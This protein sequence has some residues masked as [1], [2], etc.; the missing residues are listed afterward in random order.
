M[1]ICTG[2]IY[3]RFEKIG[4]SAV[5]WY[6]NEN[7]DENVLRLIGLKSITLLAGEDGKVPQKLAIIPFPSL[8][9]ALTGTVKFI[10]IKDPEARGG[11]R[12]STLTVLFDQIYDAVIY[13]HMMTEFFENLINEAAK[14]IINL[15]EKKEFEAEKYSKIIK[16]L[17]ETIEKSLRK[18]Q[19]IEE[20]SEFPSDEMEVTEAHEYKF[21]VICIGD[22]AVGKTTTVLRYVDRAFRKLYIPTIGVQVSTKKVYLKKIKTSVELVIWDIA[23]QEKFNV[24][25]KMFYK[26]A[27]G[28]LILYDITNEETFQSLKKWT[29]DYVKFYEK[30]EKKLPLTGI[31]LG[32]KLDLENS[33]QVKN[34]EGESFAKQN[35]MFFYEI[36][37]LTGENID[38]VF[39]TIASEMANAYNSMKD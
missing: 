4:P 13:K 10:E 5:S 1:S 21:K 11:A 24:M 32:N 12:D 34:E 35:G 28:V 7:I 27:D 20:E 29:K 31:I 3:S 19:Q 36:S 39:Q 14:K 23:G 18:L 8:K 17:Y 33:R 22:P 37:A 2:V 9:P 26:G 25:R 15:E 6:P 16:G 30:E 38:N